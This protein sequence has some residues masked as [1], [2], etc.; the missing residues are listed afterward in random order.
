MTEDEHIRATCDRARSLA[1]FHLWVI[2]G[3]WTP[4]SEDILRIESLD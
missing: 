1:N 3:E 4:S 2:V